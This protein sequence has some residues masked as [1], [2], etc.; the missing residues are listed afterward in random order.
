MNQRVVYI[1]LG[2]SRTSSVHTACISVENQELISDNQV[3]GQYDSVCPKYVIEEEVSRCL[4]Y[5]LHWTVLLTVTSKG[6]YQLGD[7]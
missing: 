3:S 7:S 5:M 2:G 1:Q 6:P 4:Q